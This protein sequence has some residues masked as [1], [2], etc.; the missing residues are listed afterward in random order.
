MTKRAS[1]WKKSKAT[2]ATGKP[3]A[4]PKKE[5]LEVFLAQVFLSI[6]VSFAKKCLQ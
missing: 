3:L 2:T 5:T 4:T 1:H 6:S